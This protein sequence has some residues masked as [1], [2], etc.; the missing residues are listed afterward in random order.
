MHLT[1]CILH[2]SGTEAGD[3]AGC[4]HCAADK[5][6][7]QSGE[8]VPSLVRLDDSQQRHR[9]DHRD[10]DRSRQR[11]KHFATVDSCQLGLLDHTHRLYIAASFISS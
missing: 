4:K 5:R 2:V 9:A 8:G 7:Q 6:Q 10:F 11:D 1:T 3:C